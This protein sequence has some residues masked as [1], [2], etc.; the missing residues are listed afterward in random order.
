MTAEDRVAIDR[1][2]FAAWSAYAEETG[3]EPAMPAATVVVLRDGPSGPE[4]LMLRKNSKI[5]FG[6]MWV[7]PGGKVDDE[8]WD[9]ADD[10]LHAARNA[11]IREAEEEARLRVEAHEMVVFAH[12]IPPAIAPKRYATWFFAAPV[13]D[14]DVIIDDG[15]IVEMEWTTPDAALAKHH[16]GEIE[17]VPPTW[18]TLDALTGHDTVESLL[19]FLDDRPAR[20]HATVVARGGEHPVVMWAGDAGYE[21]ADAT[22]HGPRH[23]LTMAPGGHVYED[24][25]AIE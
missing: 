11:A 7:F 22:V 4:T 23:R 25:G 15:E 3:D 1:K 21:T 8:D 6:G 5:A 18:V 17:I 14:D 9:G 12:W 13:D 24:D 16:E 2:R 20:H 19:A 10:A